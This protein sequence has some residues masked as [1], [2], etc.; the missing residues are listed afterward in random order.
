M[1]IP[2]P[3]LDDRRWTDLVEESR[4]LIPVLAI[5]GVTFGW[6]LGNSILVEA[7]FS[8]SGLGLLIIK[9][10]FARDYQLVQA[11]IAV[12]ALAIVLINIGLDVLYAV[13]D[14]RVRHA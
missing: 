12:L 3:E 4:A 7:V 14:P 11:S 8:R 9:A 6:A 10:V 13:V 2:L 5:V 1:L